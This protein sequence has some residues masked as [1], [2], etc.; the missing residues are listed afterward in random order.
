MSLA[1][2]LKCE[3]SGKECHCVPTSSQVWKAFCRLSPTPSPTFGGGSWEN[4]TVS[5]ASSFFASVVTSLCA[6]YSLDY[7]EV[8]MELYGEEEREEVDRGGQEYKR[9]EWK[10]ERQIQPVSS[11]LGVLHH[12]EHTEIQS[13]I[14]KRRGRKETEATWWRKKESKGGENG[15]A[16]NLALR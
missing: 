6:L 14:E 3:P 2:I 1:W 10:G 7:S 5:K 4:S 13:W 15:Q 12:L 8:F 9:G 11:S 16:N